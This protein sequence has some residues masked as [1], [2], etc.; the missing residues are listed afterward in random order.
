[1]GK[2]SAGEQEPG[3][4]SNDYQYGSDNT[5]DKICHPHND[6]VA[7]ITTQSPSEEC[8]RSELHRYEC[9][10]HRSQ[11]SPAD[12]NECGFKEA[13]A[14]VPEEQSVCSSSHQEYQCKASE[15]EKTAYQEMSPA[16]SDLTGCIGHINFL[17]KHIR[18]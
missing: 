15:T 17:V 16:V 11:K 2:S 8:V 18:L 6:S 10:Y 7:G 1:M 4:D 9:Q 14:P 5:T 3:N 13:Y 12:R